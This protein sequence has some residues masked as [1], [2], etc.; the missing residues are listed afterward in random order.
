LCS[1]LTGQV[2]EGGARSS[3]IGK[4]FFFGPEFGGTGYEAAARAA[5]GM[6]NV[7]HFVV[8]DIFEGDLDQ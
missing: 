8:E 7:E 2:V 4:E 5:G 3:E 1:R 6:L